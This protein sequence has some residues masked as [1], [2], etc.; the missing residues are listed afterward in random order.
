MA[1]FEGL[2]Q[3]NGAQAN[4]DGVRTEFGATQVG[5]SGWIVYRINAAHQ[6]RRQTECVEADSGPYQPNGGGWDLQSG[7]KLAIT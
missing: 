2:S 4:P 3:A 5:L 7:E 6:I 1:T